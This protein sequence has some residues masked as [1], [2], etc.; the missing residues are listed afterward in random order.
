MPSMIAASPPEQLPE[1]AAEEAHSTC[2][3]SPRLPAAPHVRDHS[4]LEAGGSWPRVH[5][6]RRTSTRGT[7][8]HGNRKHLR[9]QRPLSH[10]SPKR[11]RAQR[12][13]KKRLRG[14]LCHE[15]RRHLKKQRPLRTSPK[16]LECPSTCVSE[17]G[18]GLLH[19]TRYRSQQGAGSSR[20]RV[21]GPA[22]A[23]RLGRSI[24]TV[25]TQCSGLGPARRGH[26]PR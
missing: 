3:S 5:R 7:L 6:K 17:P 25:H 2:R 14:A 19:A 26:R 1:A 10:T 13:R 16:T 24:R 15:D 21:C 22:S 11:H 18:S 20:C 9:K 12:N 4:P 8:C 23:L